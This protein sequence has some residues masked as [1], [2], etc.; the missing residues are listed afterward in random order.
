MH[1]QISVHGFRCPEPP[2]RFPVGR[3]LSRPRLMARSKFTPSNRWVRSSVVR[4]CCRRPARSDT[5]SHPLFVDVSAA[6]RKQ[7]RGAASGLM[8][9]GS[10]L[11]RRCSDAQLTTRNGRQRHE[12]DTESR[13]RKRGRKATVRKEGNFELLQSRGQEANGRLGG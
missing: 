7:Q 10:H 9:T 13:W 6:A 4:G 3:H 2:V 12:R 8:L 1:L 5:V 11:D